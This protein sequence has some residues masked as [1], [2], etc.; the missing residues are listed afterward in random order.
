M[1]PIQLEVREPNSGATFEVT[2]IGVLE[3]SAIMGYGLITSQE[4]LKK[5]LNIVCRSQPTSSVWQ[6]VSIPFRPAQR[7]RALS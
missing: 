1:K 5:G 3:Q 4:T 7:W 2:V 6:T